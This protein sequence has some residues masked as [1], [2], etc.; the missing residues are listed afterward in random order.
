VKAR[1][2][3]PVVATTLAILGIAVLAVVMLSVGNAMIKG[4]TPWAAALAIVAW[5]CIR[6]PRPPFWQDPDPELPVE[7]VAWELVRTFLRNRD[8]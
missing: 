7:L 6:P 8:R 2:I 1:R 3:G 5:R 4:L